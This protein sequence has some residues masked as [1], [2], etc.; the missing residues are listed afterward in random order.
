[1][2]FVIASY[3]V[4]CIQPRTAA[5]HTKGWLAVIENPNVDCLGHC[6]NPAF[7]MDAAAVVEACAQNRKLIEI[8]SSSFKIRPGSDRTCREI[9]L[10]CAKYNVEILVNSDA[11]SKWQVGEQQDALQL[12]DEIDFPE[13][14]VVNAD[15]AR[16]ISYFSSK[17][18][19]R[20]C[21]VCPQDAAHKERD[22]L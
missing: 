12:L 18:Q 10:L 14:L 3:H 20:P 22:V 13:H 1:M 2:D 17:R 15:K 19:E 6:G 21:G 8:N 11:H 9:A 5:E 7:P 16:L 4:E